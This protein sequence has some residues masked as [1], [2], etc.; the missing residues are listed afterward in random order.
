MRLLWRT[1]GR[2]GGGGGGGERG[3]RGEIGEG[4]GGEGGGKQLKIALLSSYPAPF[5][6]SFLD[7][8]GLG[9]MKQDDITLFSFLSGACEC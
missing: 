7:K 6:L 1:K 5:R 2:S 4:G 9:I 3:G 8:R